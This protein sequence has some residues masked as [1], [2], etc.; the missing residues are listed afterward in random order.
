MTSP[1]QNQRT[2]AKRLTSKRLTSAPGVSVFSRSSLLVLC[3]QAAQMDVR[4]SMCEPNF[5][6]EGQ[7]RGVG[8]LRVFERC[9][10]RG[11]QDSCLR[12]HGRGHL[13]QATEFL[14]GEWTQ[15]YRLR[16]ASSA[17]RSLRVQLVGVTGPLD[18]DSILEDRFEQLP[19]IISG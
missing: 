1:A 6:A 16:R 18:P 4:R 7:Q 13:R 12:L 17:G 14:A 11:C 10:E 15:R 19:S 9:G 5:D 2:F 8:H 3:Y